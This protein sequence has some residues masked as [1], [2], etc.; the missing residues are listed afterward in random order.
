MV[1]HLRVTV[2]FTANLLF[3]IILFGHISYIIEGRNP[4]FGVWMHFS[5]VESHIPFLGHFDFTSDLVCRIIVS[6]TYL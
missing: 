5:M 2:T 6:R 1:F 4:K 3:R